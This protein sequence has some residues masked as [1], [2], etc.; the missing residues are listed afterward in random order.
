MHHNNRL[1]ER[2]VKRG[3]A[4]RSSLKGREK[5]IVNP[6]NIGTLSKAKLGKLL[7]DGVERIL[8]STELNNNFKLVFTA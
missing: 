7:R 6:T 1:E 3:S 2:G 4:R 5:A 8:N